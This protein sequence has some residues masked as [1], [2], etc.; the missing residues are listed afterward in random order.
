MSDLLT[1]S[2]ASDTQTQTEDAA[3]LTEPTPAPDVATTQASPLADTPQA[4]PVYT[5]IDYAAK[6]AKRRKEVDVMA[7]IGPDLKGETPELKPFQTQ[8]NALLD[9]KASMDMTVNWRGTAAFM[10]KDV[11]EL[12]TS[13]YGE[14]K[15]TI[16]GALNRPVPKSE[17]EY[18]SM[19]TEHFTKEKGVDDAFDAIQHKAVMDSWQD[20]SK[21]MSAPITQR[22]SEWSAE[23][24]DVLKGIPESQKLAE[25]SRQYAGVRSM[26][27]SPNA[28]LAKELVDRLQTINPEAD[29]AERGKQFMSGDMGQVLQ[30]FT[31]GPTADPSTQSDLIDKLANLSPK[32]RQDVYAMAGAYSKA[33]TQGQ[34]GYIPELYNLAK[35][36]TRAAEGFA[37]NM[38]TSLQER[39]NRDSIDLPLTKTRAEV[40]PEERSAADK[41]EKY[42]RVASELS[43]AAKNQINPLPGSAGLNGA[44]ETIGRSL[45]G[46]AP[47]VAT[48]LMQPEIGVP[49]LY[50]SITADTQQRLLNANPNLSIRDAGITS[51]IEAIPQTA[52]MY[53][54]V[55]LAAKSFPAVEGI[56]A[57]IATNPS[58]KAKIL[59][60]AIH[61]GGGSAA[62]FASGV[63]QA[64]GDKI[65][66]AINSD[67][68]AGPELS[69][70]LATL[71]AEVPTNFVSFLILGYAM[72]HANS[73]ELK[74]AIDEAGSTYKLRILG[75]NEE[76]A[77]KIATAD[78]STRLS[79][80]RKETPNRTEESIKAGAELARSQKQVSLDA[81]QDTESPNHTILDDGTHVFTI[82]DGK[83]GQREISRTKDTQDAAAIHEQL[84]K[85]HDAEQI[86]DLNDTLAM[87]E[88]ADKEQGV[89]GT[90]K[91]D[92][93]LKKVTFQDMHDAGMPMEKLK[94]SMRVAG[95]N[96]DR[97]LSDVFVDGLTESEMKD[98]I[99]TDTLKIN[100]LSP[101][102]AIHE[103]LDASTKRV[104]QSGKIPLEQFASWIRQT[105]Q[106]TGQ[107][108]MNGEATAQAITEAVTSIGEEYIAGH[109]NVIRGTASPLA[110]FYKSLVRY[111][112]NL[113]G[114]SKV[115]RESFK[116]GKIDSSF[117]EHLARA[118]G[119]PISERLA[120]REATAKAEL[121]GEK[122]ENTSFS[123]SEKEPRITEEEKRDGVVVTPETGTESGTPAPDTK[124]D[125]LPLEE[126]DDIPW[127]D[128]TFSISP[129]H[130][131][132]V[133]PAMTKEIYDEIAKDTKTIAAI[134]I[135]RMKVGEYSGIPLQGGMFYPS[136]VDNLKKG[137]AWAFNAPNVA[138]SVA[139]RAAANGGYVKLVL[140]QEGNVVGNK[141]FGNIW[142]TQLQ[143]AI[144]AKKISKVD[145]LKELNR[146]RDLNAKTTGHDAA[147][148]SINEA[149]DAII[150]MPQQKRGST[151]FQKSQTETKSEG[152]KIAYQSLL[153]QKMTKLGFPN[154][155]EIVDS[156]EEPS[157]KG[158]PKGATVG[159]LK[160]DPHPEDAPIL[161]AKEA[162]VPEH[163]SYGYVL[164]GKP[165]ARMTKY[166]VV[167]EQFPETKNQIL[168][169]QHTD[170]PLEQSVTFS[171]RARE[172]AYDAAVKAGD[173]AGQ[174]RLVDEAAK[175]AGYHTEVFK[176]WMPF[177]G[178][179]ADKNFK[180]ELIGKGT[181]EPITTFERQ[182]KFPTFISGEPQL[183]GIKG[184]F[185]S[186][187]EV[188]D[189]FS[190]HGGEWRTDG[191]YIND[192]KQLVIDAKGKAAGL[193]QFERNDSR[194]RDAVRSGKY[195]SILLKNTS[196][197]ADVHVMLSSENIKSADPITRD[198]AGNVIP[199]SQRFNAESNDIRFSIST[200]EERE[201]INQEI[202]NRIGT[203]P[204]ARV[205][206]YERMQ[207]SL[208]RAQAS[209]D[210]IKAAFGDKPLSWEDSSKLEARKMEQSLVEV[211]AIVSS[212]PPDI[213]SAITRNWGNPQ[214]G[215]VG[216]VYTKYTSL[217][218]DKARA[219]FL[220]KTIDRANDLIDRSLPGEYRDKIEETLRKAKPT[221]S[222]GG[223]KKSKYDA[224]T[225]EYADMAYKA[226]LLNEQDT[227][228][229]LDALEKSITDAQ[230]PEEEA[231]LV[232]EWAIT[233][234][235]GNL[236]KQDHRKLG[237]TL[238]E[239]D[240][241][242][243]GGREARRIAE[244]ARIDDIREMQGN[245]L[246]NSA[247]WTDTGLDKAEKGKNDIL[248]LGDQLIW[249]HASYEA[250]LRRILP[251]GLEGM[252]QD[253]SNRIRRANNATEKAG[254][255]SW[256]GLIKSVQDGIGSKGF[257]KTAEAMS[258]LQK[259]VSG[260]VK[261]IMGRKTEEVY[262]TIDKAEAILR[263]EAHPG[264]LTK[265]ERESMADELAT[266]P[267]NSKKKGVTITRMVEEGKEADMP[268]SLNQM[269][270]ATMAWEQK[271][272]REKMASSGWTQE[273]YDQ[274]KAEIANSKVASAVLD[275]L[276][277]F[278]KGTA[279]TINPVHTRMYGMRLPDNP[280]YAP[281]SY[282]TKQNGNDI[283]LGGMNAASASTTPG[284]LKAR[285]KH[286]ETF[287]LEDAT[288]IYQSRAMQIAQWTS[289]AEL[290]R[291]INAVLND[292]NVRLTMTQANGVRL[293]ELAARMIDTLGKGGGVNT[294]PAYV[295]KW[296]GAAVGGT[297][298]SAMGF[299]LKS[300]VNQFDA[301][302]RFL[303]AMPFKDV[304]KS[305]ADPAG[306]MASMPAAWN[307]DAVQNRIKAGSNPAMRFVLKQSGMTTSKFVSAIHE[308]AA[309]SLK[310][311][312]YADGYLT[313]LSSAIVYR[314]A[315]AK[316]LE[317]GLSPKDAEARAL[318]AMD[319]AIYR[320]SQPVMFSAKSDVENTSNAATKLLYLF[321]SDARL[322]TGIIIDAVHGITSGKGDKGEHLKKIGVV[323]AAAVM[324]QTISNAYRDIFSDD[325]D[326]EIWT[327]G[328][329]AK[330]VALAPFAGYF[331]IGTALDVALGHMTGQ[332]V[333][334]SSSNPVVNAEQNVYNAAKHAPDAFQT[335]DTEKLLK[336]LGR[337]SKAVSVT[338]AMAVPGAIYNPIKTAIGAK[339]NIDKGQ[340]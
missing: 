46:M 6:E 275:H 110:G 49:L 184:F 98:G 253:W 65:A 124:V 73:G 176:G 294:D 148:T 308:I 152:V 334:N 117:E 91:T 90:R 32:E 76:Q 108:Y 149:Q 172:E 60:A 180:G 249:S 226:S 140:M 312:M 24:A 5:G 36:F 290:H 250:V 328:G 10:G 311:M 300:I 13:R 94:A 324:A 240:E 16:A 131:P 86:K 169:Q 83:G 236:A 147:W 260:K 164:K 78:P 284:L 115:L 280:N 247:G 313:T 256:E 195:D 66:N 39:I 52:L 88:Q 126:G 67:I 171:I 264:D 305:L 182:S 157:F 330:A 282:W 82:P 101:R 193:L 105:E 192:G 128:T 225:Q 302:T 150:S 138:R 34:A 331:L 112:N 175:E 27:A 44:V 59:N 48:T 286:G 292:K 4:A 227:I 238:N 160:F 216:N 178:D 335:D 325:T 237:Q 206:I 210:E 15:A 93:S 28:P 26:F 77:Q 165:V 262:I 196:D 71:A 194:F 229:R 31:S 314:D 151:Y 283:A 144:D 319:A 161:T 116:S 92:V 220:I 35:T 159:I 336:E 281:T 38:S 211:N 134:H 137:V 8:A 246:E 33:N 141:T 315:H 25:F 57:D 75:F 45:A 85:M 136:I 56:L 64:V 135:D 244:Q 252:V 79:V 187:K 80:L 121:M 279:D 63:S 181:K 191:F 296:L 3:F 318:D 213:K 204:D 272:V 188:A 231:A 120:P 72:S 257:F 212:L 333:Y 200:R 263:G 42:L 274:M 167:D 130:L 186:S 145:A 51:Q 251:Q 55:G 103:R 230:T 109:A 155:R 81:V 29:V 317:S 316:A 47:I 203:N 107:S 154:A 41:R 276:K 304:I 297:A 74:Q 125:G 177:T 265:A 37:G 22:F 87:Q 7:R 127:A 254:L 245:I 299:N 96:E 234:Q 215:V 228:A 320:F 179:W 295:K 289:F 20:N 273:S 340:D 270:F 255:T 95:I 53:A 111:F 198:D 233:N 321:A 122:V 205:K 301:S 269:I 267:L 207:K 208:V 323:L 285:V 139:R 277:D 298:V 99:Y 146:V 106:A 307:S 278:Y 9:S 223:V 174:Q 123:A 258:E 201:R 170:F 293:Q 89:D 168:T 163:M 339:K 218:S 197:E 190:A 224:A 132:E 291:E 142:F 19:L 12:E 84:W 18:R 158:V 162:G 241:A 183:D 58:I 337:I 30:S 143:E 133:F 288:D 14:Y 214:N 271:D 221:K 68:D 100:N 185:S 243:A 102:T 306:V 156:I 259:E 332:K 114:R 309:V 287:K 322:R 242:I 268:M 248:S 1:S 2:L 310:P 43:E 119:L 261:K 166:K 189:R 23:H 97:S 61:S 113:L 232:D 303:Y 11:S 239:L 62:M 209:M 202:Q 118:I 266:L 327:W 173:E 217:T 69:K 129:Q 338:P 222:E 153:A 199:L 104:V 219:D 54:G 17:G 21:G 70:Q 326:T 235:Y 329:Y 50:A 40:T